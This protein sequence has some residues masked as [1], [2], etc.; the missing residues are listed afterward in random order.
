[1][2]LFLQK[3]KKQINKSTE[4]VV[5]FNQSSDVQSLCVLAHFRRFSIIVFVRSGFFAGRQQ[6]KPI[7]LS[8]RR[9]VMSEISIPDSSIKFV[10]IFRGFFLFWTHISFIFRSSRGVVIFFLPDFPVLIGE[11]AAF[12]LIFF[13][14]LSTDDFATPAIIAIFLCEW[15]VFNSRVLISE[16]FAGERSFRLPI[17][18]TTSYHKN[19]KKHNQ[20]NLNAHKFKI[21]IIHTTHLYQVYRCRNSRL[22]FFNKKLLN[23]LKKYKA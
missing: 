1:M 2:K 17:A 7:S 16:I 8:R 13:F 10:R 19:S 23:R 20:H 15:S 9:T 12:A 14:I 5:T 21:K 18:K 11:R 4:R 6:V 3:I 22:W